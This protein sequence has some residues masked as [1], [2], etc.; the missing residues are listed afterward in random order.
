MIHIYQITNNKNN[1][2]YIGQ[3]S[4]TL[5]KRFQHHKTPSSECLK[6]K[7]AFNK[8][9]R[10]NFKIELLTVAHTQEI[11]D[12]W[13]QFFIEKYNSITNGYNIR[14]GGNASPMKGRTHTDETKKKISKASSQ[15]RHSD[16]TKKKMSEINIGRIFTDE[17]K[18]K[19]SN[20]AMGNKKRAGSTHSDES[21]KKMS[22]AIKGCTWKLVNG[23]R[24][25]T[26]KK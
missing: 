22:L 14:L 17:S 24:V 4:Q 6:L 25:Y 16:E 20:S 8:Y 26:F 5:K 10:D 7:A 19:M 23:K 2:V 13:E 9:G 21:K 11:A 18:N 15:Y 12:Y 1:K 3:T